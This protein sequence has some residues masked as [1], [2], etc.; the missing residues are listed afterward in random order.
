[1]KLRIQFYLILCL[2]VLTGAGIA[3][4]KVFK[5][6]VPIVPGE[7]VTRWIV[8]AKITFFATGGDVTARLSLPEQDVAN[9]SVRMGRGSAFRYGFAFDERSGDPDAVWTSSEGKEGI[10]TLYFRVHVEQ[11]DSPTQVFPHFGAKPEVDKPVFTGVEADAAEG[12]V[13]RVKIDSV[14]A[15]SF[16]R[17]IL[18]E[19]VSYTHLTL[20]TIC[21]V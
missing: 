3:G 10:Q 9:R 13:D 20:P 2:L 6:G 18:L 17:H 1:M 19:P 7:N 12:M 11:G 21:S 8:E 14:G 16:T 15:E 5:L 4:Y